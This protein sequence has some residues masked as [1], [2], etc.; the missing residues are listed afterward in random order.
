MEGRVDL[1]TDLRLPRE[2]V[3]AVPEEGDRA[4]FDGAWG[5]GVE[6]SIPPLPVSCGPV[7]REVQDDACYLTSGPWIVVARMRKTSSHW[8]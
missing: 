2:A 1:V 8:L 4:G 3:D 5:Q 6:Q 7:G